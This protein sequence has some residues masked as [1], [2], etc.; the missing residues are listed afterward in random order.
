MGALTNGLESPLSAA[1][2]LVRWTHG[3]VVGFIESAPTSTLHF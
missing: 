2:P 1:D 3:L